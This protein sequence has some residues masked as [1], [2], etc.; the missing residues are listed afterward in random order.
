MNR[1]TTLLVIAVALAVYGVYAA[2]VVPAMLVGPAVVGLLVGFILQAVCAIAA[3]FAV[4]RRLR[5]AAARW[6]FSGCASPARGSSRALSSGSS[7]IC[8]PCWSR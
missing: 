4:W 1:S 8:T 5:W 7:P 2:S 3:A 6:C